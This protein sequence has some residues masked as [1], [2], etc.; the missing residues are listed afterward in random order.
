[1][2]P[3]IPLKEELRRTTEEA[4]INNAHHLAIK[5]QNAVHEAK[6]AMM[7]EAKRGVSTL[8][9]E[10]DKDVTGA[11]AEAY[12]GIYRSTYEDDEG[13]THVKFAW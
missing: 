5:C 3:F 2:N 7:A 8:D 1:M 12:P 6:I 10:C 4:R 9:Y 13:K 11:I